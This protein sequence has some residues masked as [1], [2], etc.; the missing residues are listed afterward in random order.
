MCKDLHIPGEFHFQKTPIESDRRH[1]QVK[2]TEVS[3]V[4]VNYIGL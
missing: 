4:M 2:S 3:L 1:I